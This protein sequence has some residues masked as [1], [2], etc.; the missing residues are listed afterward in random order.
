[1]DVRPVC[2]RLLA[3]GMGKTAVVTALV[4]A[5]PSTS[6][7]SDDEWKARTTDGAAPAQ[8]KMT[9]VICNNTL[10][11]QWEDEVK[12]FAPKLNV[13]T[14]YASGTSDAAKK[15]KQAMASLRDCDV[16]ITTPHMTAQAPWSTILKNVH[17]HRLVVDEAHL[18]VQ[19]TRT[20]PHP[21]LLTDALEGAH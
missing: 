3:V 10:V 17:A 19:G 12:S 6:R 9:I 20:R 7:P 15:K 18:C 5:N 16:L 11:Q 8:Y 14:Y 4:L 1:M 21:F 13:Q 2:L